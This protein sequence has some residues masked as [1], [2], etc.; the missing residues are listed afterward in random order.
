MYD[1]SG[2]DTRSRL[3]NYLKT[4]GFTRVQRSF[5]VGR[6]P[7]SILRDVERSLPRFIKSGG[8][9]IHLIPVPEIVVKGLKVYGKPLADITIVSRLTVIA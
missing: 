4:R 5:F 9:V 3:A 1:I 2:N 8:D 7:S 6:P